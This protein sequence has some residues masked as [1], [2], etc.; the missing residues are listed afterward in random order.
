M[1]AHMVVSVNGKKRLEID[2]PANAS[3]TEVEKTV[4]GMEN[5]KPY[6]QGK[7]PKKVIV[8]KNKLVNIVV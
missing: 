7:T 5:L 6:L 3:D 2:V 8:V 1:A 4:L